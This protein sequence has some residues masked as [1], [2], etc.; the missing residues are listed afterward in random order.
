MSSPAPLNYD[1][2]MVPDYT[3]P[4]LLV[5]SDGSTVKTADDW[6]KRRRPESLQLFRHCMYGTCPEPDYSN[7]SCEMMH[8]ILSND[9]NSLNGLA[10]LAKKFS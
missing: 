5:C 2:S 10:Q 8:K 9:K 4:K 3:L 7:T 1:E 6:N